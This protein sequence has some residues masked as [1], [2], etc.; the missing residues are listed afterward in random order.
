MASLETGLSEIEAAFQKFGLSLPVDDNEKMVD[1]PN[2]EDTT[3]H[4]EIVDAS[5]DVAPNPSPRSVAATSDMSSEGQALHL[6]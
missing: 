5:S 4:I 6:L 1:T 3:T 2:T